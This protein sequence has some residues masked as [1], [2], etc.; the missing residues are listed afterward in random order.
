MKNAAIFGMQ[1]SEISK[2]E[3][4]SMGINYGLKVINSRHVELNDPNINEG[5][6]I[7]TVNE[8]PIKSI[9]HFEEMLKDSDGVMI[10]GIYSDGTHDHYYLENVSL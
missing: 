4:S 7:T 3:R 10:G 5:F 1:V 9:Q 8:V 6:I 2:K